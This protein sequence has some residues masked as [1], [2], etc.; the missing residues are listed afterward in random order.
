MGEIIANVEVKSL[1]HKRLIS[2]VCEEWGKWDK[3]DDEQNDEQLQFDNFYHGFMQP[4][5]GYYRCVTTKKGSKALD[6]DENGYID[7]KELLVYIKWAL[8]EYPNVED[9]ESLLKIKGVMP[10]MRDEVV[11]HNTFHRLTIKL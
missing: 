4:Y 6:M 11:R 10:V 9:A 7:W 5:F 2:E 1:H 3:Q 8:R